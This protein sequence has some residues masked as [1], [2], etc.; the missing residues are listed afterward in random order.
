VRPYVS[1]IFFNRESAKGAVE[2]GRAR[3]DIS[4]MK[5]MKNPGPSPKPNHLFSKGL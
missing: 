3:A 2:I 1:S 5:K 4:Y